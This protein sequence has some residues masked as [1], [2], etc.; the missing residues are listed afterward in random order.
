M[1][2]VGSGL[3]GGLSPVSAW[4]AFGDGTGGVALVGVWGDAKADEEIG[5]VE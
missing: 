1:L 2:D 5:V 3:M 4:S